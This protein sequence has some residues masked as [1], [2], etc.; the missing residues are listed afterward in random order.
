MAVLNR[1]RQ[2]R[3]AQSDLSYTVAF[4]RGGDDIVGHIFA[5]LRLG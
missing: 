4:V 2:P 3:L 1:F 5:S